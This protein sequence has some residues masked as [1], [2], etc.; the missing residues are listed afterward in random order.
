MNKLIKK[1][2]FFDPHYRFKAILIIILL[3]GS[4]I[5]L[6]HFI[7][8][9]SLWMDE[10]YLCSGFVHMNYLELAS[11]ILDYQQK[12]PIGFLWMVKLCTDL[13]GYHEMSLRTIPLIAG[14]VSLFLFAD[15]CKYYLKPLPLRPNSSQ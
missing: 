6:F 9:R 7:N 5:R 14:I 13:F 2:N 15:V 11:N 1:N 8:N 4:A 12:A 10:I 3:V